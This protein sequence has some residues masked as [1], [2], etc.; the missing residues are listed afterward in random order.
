MPV[1][2]RC[3]KIKKYYEDKDICIRCARIVIPYIFEEPPIDS[4]KG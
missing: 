2:A 4:K 3:G 1:C